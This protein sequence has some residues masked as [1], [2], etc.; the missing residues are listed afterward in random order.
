MALNNGQQ[1]A[2]Q[3][4]KNFVTSD[5]SFAKIE[6]SP[7]TGKSF[8]TARIPTFVNPQHLALLA[9]THKALATLTK[10]CGGDQ[11]ES[12]TIHS[13]LGLGVKQVKD[14]QVSYRRSNYD[15]TEFAHIR[16]VVLDEMSMLDGNLVNFIR[17]DA[18]EWGRKYILIGDHCQLPPV[19]GDMKI[20]DA[21]TLA[22]PQYSYTLD[23]VVRQAKDNPIIQVARGVRQ[24]VLEGRE[25]DVKGGFNEDTGQG[26]ILLRKNAW[27]EKMEETV[28][29]PLL[30][31]DVDYC[32]VIAY[33]NAA[34]KNH[35]K[36]V[37]QMTGASPEKP[38]DEGDTVVVNSAYS[39]NYQVILG[40]GTEVIVT[41]MKKGKHVIKGYS[42]WKVTV[43]TLGG[44][45]I[46]KTFSVLD[47]SSR[48]EYDKEVNRLRASCSVSGQWGAYYA[49]VGHYLDLRPPYALTA[50]KSQGSTFKNVF[51]DLADIYS[52]RKQ[53]V[54]DRCYY[55]ALTRASSSVF[56]LV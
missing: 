17:Q 49:L 55:V 2:E 7:G 45:A 20:S 53:T 12:R 26:V 4:L 42:E 19:E 56:V 36:V 30:H 29:D 41:S 23:E 10:M 33:T 15:P 13:F 40:T 46:D 28:N 51:I 1:E 22:S 3:M 35:I 31:Q 18:E 24:A 5:H 43:Q 34:C 8:L 47:E 9:P 44:L 25:P 32:R 52:N 54:A 14:K 21:F 11:V 37:R 38:F 16:T 39:E 48:G 27:L 50:H 6:G